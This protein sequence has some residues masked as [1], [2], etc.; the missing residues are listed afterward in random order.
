[1]QQSKIGAWRLCV[2]VSGLLCLA[3]AA[4]MVRGDTSASAP[5]PGAAARS[6]DNG[7]LGDTSAVPTIKLAPLDS[8]RLAAD[9]GLS[10]QGQ[11]GVERE[12]PEIA[13]RHLDAGNPGG[14]RWQ[15]G[16]PC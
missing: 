10:E 15:T 11:V 16:G 6:A 5:T 7:L 12:P 14:R 2:A 3:L 13:T 9:P 4:P 1:M 8:D